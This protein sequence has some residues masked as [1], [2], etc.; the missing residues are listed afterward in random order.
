MWYNVHRSSASIVR[1]STYVHPQLEEYSVT[2]VEP[3]AGWEREQLPG[4]VD[5]DRR[6]NFVA[7]RHES[8]DVRIRIAPPNQDLNRSAHAL[9]LTVFPGTELAETRT[10]REVA[11]E[12]RA[13]ELA[14]S[15]MKLFN[16]AYDG[17]GSVEHAADFAI[18]R[19]SP[20]DVVLES[21]VTNDE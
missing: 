1:T 8:G 18:E 4:G 2:E 7:F 19:V 14:V 12:A 17:P 11:S 3:P 16:G 21:L 15:A 5:D 9:T 13:L 20:A 10:V 6:P